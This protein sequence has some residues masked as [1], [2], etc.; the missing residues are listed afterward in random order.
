MCSNLLRGAVFFTLCCLV[1]LAPAETWNGAG[2]A[3]NTSWQ[4]PVNWGGTA[5]AAG[6]AL[7]FPS[8]AANLTANN[9]FALNSTFGPITIL[10]SGYTLTGAGIT[11]NGGINVNHLGTA[12]SNIGISLPLV[13]NTSQVITVND[14]NARLTLSGVIT[15]SGGLTKTGSGYLVLVGNSHNYSGPTILAGGALQ[16]MGTIPGAVQLGSGYLI[17][18]GTV[19]GITSLGQANANVS[20][21]VTLAGELTSI[22]NVQLLP[23]DAVNFDITSGGADQLDVT[24]TVDLGG[25]AFNWLVTPGFTPTLSTTYTLINNDGTDAV[26][27][28]PA[29]APSDYLYSI[30]PSAATANLAYQISLVGG[31]GNDVV[32]RRVPT[33]ASTTTLT[34]QVVGADVTFR[35]QVTGPLSGSGRVT[36]RSGTTVI[37]GGVVNLTGGQSQAELVNPLLPAGQHQITAMYE[38]TAVTPA[39]APSRSAVISHDTG[40]ATATTVTVDPATHTAGAPITLHATV[41]GASGTP[42][43]PVEFF[44]GAQSLGTV[45]FD[46]ITPAA[47]PVT[48]TVGSHPLR[49]LFGTVT[50]FQASLS[51]VVTYVVA[52]TATTT[53]LTSSASSAA[54]GTSLTFTA[55]VVD[56]TTAAVSGGT[57]TFQDGAAVLGTV[58]VAAGGQAALTTAGLPMGTRAITATYSGTATF[59]PSAGALTPA[60]VVTA[61][62]GGTTPSPG[63]A[64]AEESG[65]CGLGSGVAALAMALAFLLLRLRLRRD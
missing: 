65:G 20:P 43:G 1:S 29:N 25:A 10:A 31:D 23:S 30:A 5:P 22:G 57:V 13:L 64:D 19:R 46:G 8:G 16:V 7:I 26:I 14:A 24:G 59:A 54:A 47:M 6:A 48:L 4:A 17:G 42:I 15:G 49:A 40:I 27:L 28:A 9:T 51:P 18:T 63:G 60:Q 62:P 35:V 56:P 32:F 21:G 44:D 58:A 61:P 34:K 11:L 12:A 36:F 53:T 50:G 3:G 39:S 45:T 55:T 38:D 33:S 2:G 37:P 52:G 41:V